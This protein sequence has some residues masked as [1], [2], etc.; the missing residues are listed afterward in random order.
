M[1]RVQGELTRAT[2]HEA[3]EDWPHTLEIVA[4]FGEGRRKRR[5]VA[6]PADQ[7]FGR[8]SYGAP[9]SGDQIVNM[10]NKLRRA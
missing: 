5:A 3:N 9:M 6:I 8:G 10:I 4:Y 7:F 1:S 2:T